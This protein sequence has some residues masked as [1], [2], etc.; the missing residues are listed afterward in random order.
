MTHRHDPTQDRRTRN[1]PSGSHAFRLTLVTLL[2]TCA[3]FVSGAALQ[4]KERAE[5]LLVFSRSADSPVARQ[6]IEQHWPALQKEA[7]GLGLDIELIDVETG[8]APEGVHL[9]PLI[10]YQSPRGRAFFQ[11]RYADTGK[12]AHFIRTQRAVP[13]TSGSFEVTDAAVAKLGRARVLAPIKVTA[14]TGEL[15]KDHDEAAF[16]R[17]ARDAILDGLHRF[18]R[19]ASAVLGPSDRS[20]YMDFHPYRS[21]DGRIYIGTAL[22]S[23]FNCIEA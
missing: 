16:N 12:V 18:E 15:P 2:A 20:F 10:V 13:P 22:F 8:G 7:D 11:G 14:L 21:K 6:F 23:Q 3:T 19:T 4:A 9:T 5:E 1:Y 17:E